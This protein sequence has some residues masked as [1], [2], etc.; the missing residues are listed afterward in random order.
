MYYY[1]SIVDDDK[2]HAEL[3]TPVPAKVEFGLVRR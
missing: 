3:T 1:M 2:I